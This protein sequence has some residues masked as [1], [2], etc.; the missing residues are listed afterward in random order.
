ML[1]TYGLNS[2]LDSILDYTCDSILDSVPSFLNSIH[3]FFSADAATKK[4]RK[5][6]RAD[7][8][9]ALALSQAYIPLVLHCSNA[10]PPRSW[11]SHC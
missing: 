3:T 10:G 8:G 7:T 4:K 1:D 6:A 9:V 2:A 11:A 5:I